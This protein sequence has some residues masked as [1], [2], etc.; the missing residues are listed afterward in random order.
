MLLISDLNFFCLE[1]VSFSDSI[2][3]VGV[4]KQ[5]RWI[6]QNLTAQLTSKT[7]AKISDDMRPH[8]KYHRTSLFHWSK[9]IEAFWSIWLSTRS[10]LPSSLI[11]YGNRLAPSG[12]FKIQR[13]RKK[14]WCVY[15]TDADEHGHDTAERC[16][17]SRSC[18][19]H[20]ILR[21]WKVFFREDRLT[22]RGISN[23]RRT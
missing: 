14:D 16:P 7:P 15:A 8:R 3:P 5:N 6:C 19:D 9:I 17:K 10:W 22:F 18:P 21:V 11:P 1:S 4:P 12:F 20:N 2:C 23:S 13:S